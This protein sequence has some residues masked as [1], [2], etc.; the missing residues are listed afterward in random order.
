VVLVVLVDLVLLVE[1]EVLVATDQM[2][3]DNHLV[4]VARL[5]LQCHY[6]HQLLLSLLVLE[7]HRCQAHLTKVHQE[8]QTPHLILSYPQ[9]VEVV[10][11]TDPIL[12]KLLVDLVVEV[13]NLMVL[14]VLELLVK[15]LMVVTDLKVVTLV[16]VAV[17]LEKKVTLMRSQAVVMEYPPT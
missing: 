8:V 15:D 17:E 9:V 12:L 1:E 5:N 2:S 6:L 3:Q 14:V 7:Q 11:V 10:V 13:K 16:E 4:V